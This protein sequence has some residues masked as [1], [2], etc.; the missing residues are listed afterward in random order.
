MCG[1]RNEFAVWKSSGRFFDVLFLFFETEV[2]CVAQ[3]HLAV[4]FG[5]E[6][7]VQTFQFRATD[8]A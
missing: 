4:L 1:F 3:A 6:S 7:P 2:L 8:N 5:I